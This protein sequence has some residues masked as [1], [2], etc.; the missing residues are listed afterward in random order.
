VH[1]FEDFVQAT[2]SLKEIKELKRLLKTGNDNDKAFH[3]LTNKFPKALLTMSPNEI[4]NLFQERKISQEKTANWKRAWDAVCKNI[5]IIAQE[6]RPVQLD[7]SL[8]SKKI[9]WITG[10]STASL[11]PIFKKAIDDKPALIPTGELL[12][13]NIVPLTGELVMGL[14]GINAIALSGVGLSA[15]KGALHYAKAAKLHFAYSKDSEIEFIQ[16]VVDSPQLLSAEWTF[17]RLKIAAIRLGWSGISTQEK[18]KVI[19]NL[20]KILVRGKKS[21]AWKEHGGLLNSRITTKTSSPV[22]NKDLVP[23]DIIL[24]S[25]TADKGECYSLGVV[26]KVS[27]Q[28][29]Q[30]GVLIDG[31]TRYKYVERENAYTLSKEDGAALQRNKSQYA[32][33]SSKN[34]QGVTNKLKTDHEKIEEVITLLENTAVFD[35]TAEE[36]KLINMPGAILWG[37]VTKQDFLPVRSDIKGEMGLKGKQKLGD[38]IQVLF[39]EP[40]RIDEV[41]AYVKQHL[42]AAC[43]VHI[44]SSSVIP[45]LHAHQLKHNAYCS[46]Q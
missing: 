38:D 4:K 21:D 32:E 6:W 44:I 43:R 24:I 27:T 22:G 1:A 18:Q 37:T 20:K 11:V 10:S 42:P 35:M 2:P 19:E 26:D 40:E 14:A 25:R 16:K 30:V 33:V 45:F 9:T 46:F 12:E 39:V 36:K 7:S 5:F 13:H 15:H 3:T 31:G 23:G 28:N 29:Q 8:L 34:I 41:R 17:P